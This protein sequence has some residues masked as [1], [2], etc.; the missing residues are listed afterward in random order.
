MESTKADEEQVGGL[1]QEFRVHEHRLSTT[2]SHIESGDDILPLGFTSVA[3]GV[4]EQVFHEVLILLCKHGLSCQLFLKSLLLECCF[5]L[6]LIFN[7]L[8]ANGF[9]LCNTLLIALSPLLSHA[10]LLPKS[11]LISLQLKLHLIF[12]PT[13]GHLALILHSLSLLLILNLSSLDLKFLGILSD[14]KLLGSLFLNGE[15]KGILR[16]G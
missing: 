11:L 5:H 9:L 2:A 8:S 13:L 14:F 7:S 4:M 16:I 6:I 12:R 10:F 15:F 1:G 3:F